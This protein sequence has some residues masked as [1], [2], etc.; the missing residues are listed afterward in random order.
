M[1]SDNRNS[2]KRILGIMSGKGG[3]GKSTI[4]VMLADSLLNHGYKVGILDADISG[5]SI[6]NLLDIKEAHLS[7]ELDTINPFVTEK[8]LKVVSMNL[9]LDDKKQPVT[10]RGN[11]LSN[12][13]QQFWT[14]VNWG[15]IDYLLIDMPPGTSDIALTVLQNIHPHGIIMVS[16]PQD[17]VQH[18]VQKAIEMVNQ[19]N[20]RLLGTILNMSYYTCPHCNEDFNLYNKDEKVF[21][22]QRILGQL[23]AI[24]PLAGLSQNKGT[25]NEETQKLIDPITRVIINEVKVSALP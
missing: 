7:S 25:L 17:L 24:S 23:P 21:A 19:M 6:P 8:G 14:K 12:V 15:D 22:N 9:M 20:I 16:V 5:P 18:I 11:V 2:I 3:V 13:I 4:T 1:M 10:W